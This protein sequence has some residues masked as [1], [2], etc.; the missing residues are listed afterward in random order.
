MQKEVRCN[1]KTTFDFD[2][3]V[4]SHKNHNTQNDLYRHSTTWLYSST[5]LPT[6]ST[7]YQVDT[8]KPTSY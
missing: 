2:K 3:Q 1:K 5:P 6:T 7:E 4:V 8:F